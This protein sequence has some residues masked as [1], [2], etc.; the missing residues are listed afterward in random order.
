MPP[1]KSNDTVYSIESPWVA[2]AAGRKYRSRGGF[3]TASPS[4]QSPTRRARAGAKRNP[5]SLPR[6]SLSQFSKGA[7]TFLSPRSVHAANVGVRNLAGDANLAM[8]PFEPPGVAHGRLNPRRVEEGRGPGTLLHTDPFP[9]PAHQT[10][11]AHFGH[12]AFVQGCSC[13][14]TRAVA[15]RGCQP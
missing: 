7:F 13:F 5:L 14:R 1:N 4:C 15:G 8:K 12:P 9:F 11:H 2:C 10:G 3:L 6:P